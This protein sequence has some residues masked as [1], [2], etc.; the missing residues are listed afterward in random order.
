MKTYLAKNETVERK[1]FLIDATNMPVGRLAAETAK[2]LRGKNKPV[3]TPNVDC[4]DHVVII[5]ADKVRL[6]GNNK[7]SEPIY[8][9]SGYPG[10][11][12]QR[13]RG[14]YL[15]KMPVQ[16]VMRTVRGMLPK[17]TLGKKMLKKL[18]VYAGPEH[19]QQAQKPE[20]ISFE[21]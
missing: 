16:Y 9:H 8:R 10:G 5:N 15:E 20:A 19:E 11:L 12:K 1:W 4:G 7:A 2:I 3:F 13:P 14:E 6:T 21:K 18:R 17:N